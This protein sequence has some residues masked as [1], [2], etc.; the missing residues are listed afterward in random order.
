MYMQK[1]IMELKKEIKRATDSIPKVVQKNIAELREDMMMEI[2]CNT[3]Q[4]DK[5]EKTLSE[6]NKNMTE[7]IVNLEQRVTA[8][9]FKASKPIPREEY[10]CDDTIVATGIQ[11]DPNENIEEKAKDIIQNVL[12]HKEV[13]VVHAKRLAW[14]H[15][16]PGIV[17][18]QVG[19]LTEKIAVLKS[20]T[21][22]KEPP[23]P[24]KY[25]KVFLRSS[26]SHEQRVMEMNIQEVLQN[27]PIPSNTY[28][29][30]GSGRLVKKSTDDGQATGGTT[31]NTSPP[32]R[33]G[34]SSD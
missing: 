1:E 11:Y 31:N 17:K 33:P 12:G 29:F 16:R 6:T 18:I 21:K 20:K 15:G 3:N 30:T 24:P 10:N 8:L 23:T 32:S 22:L 26:K 2:S 28:R 4:I 34:A 25:R 13:K 14:R 7:M 9:E 5:M 19:S 27:L